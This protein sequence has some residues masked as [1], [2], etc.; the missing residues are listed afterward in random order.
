MVLL[1]SVTDTSPQKVEPMDGALRFVGT[2][3][4]DG[5]ADRAVP[6][7]VDLDGTL[8][9][10]NLF[11]ESLFV[12]A[13]AKPL[14]LLLLP[15]W[16]AQGL[17]RLKR[18]LADRFRPDIRTLPYD[19]EF[20]AYLQAQK[21]AGRTL[22]LV[23]G[24]DESLAHAVAAELGLFDRVIASDG[25]T[26]LNG[27]AKRDRLLAEFGDKGFD[28]AG[29]DRCD[30]V[31]WA[32][33]RKAILVRPSARLSD[34]QSKISV[35]ERLFPRHEPKASVYMQALRL[36]HWT[37]NAL[38]FV[39]LIFFHRLFDIAALAQAVLAFLAFSLCASSIYLLNDLTDLPEDR[40][41]PHKRH[42]MLASGQLAVGRAVA[43]IP[44]L[45][46]G[47]FIISLTQPPLFLGILAVYCGLMVVYCLRL[48][49]IAM[50]DALA[51]AAGY[52]LRVAGGS[53]AAG[54]EISAWMVVS[55]TL[56]F[57]G[58]TLLK[59]YA[60]LMTMQRLPNAAARARGYP[61]RDRS[62][63][64][65]FGCSSNY[66]ALL[67]YAF[68]VRTE[69]L[70]SPW[71]EAVWFIWVLLSY[72]VAHIWLMAGQG[73]IVADPVAFTLRDRGSQIV[74]VLFAIAVLVT[75]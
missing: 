59:R 9:G 31:V 8:T 19:R 24:A 35:I 18:R 46:S 2:P 55:V 65:L 57:F 48:R 7:A 21:R 16:F 37:K 49:A 11:L 64:A 63:I 70:A 26:N 39:P 73:R 5:S 32:I 40:R 28:Y 54:L 69:L 43:L 6:L 30:R 20:I 47:A 3:D 41:H 17:A 13:K 51:I 14:L 36:H 45:L 61:V 71:H 10:T 12:L 53:A 60:E 44:L 72:W 74:G 38:V 56:F 62:R 34:A 23:T 29:H 42:R 15:I 75:A 50:I 67:I 66:L 27:R 52:T 1:D 25:I 68:H 58:L 33:A 22:I 4:P